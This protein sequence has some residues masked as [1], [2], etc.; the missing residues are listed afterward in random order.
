MTSI[1]KSRRNDELLAATSQ[2]IRDALRRLESDVSLSPSISSLA[3]LAG[4]HRNTIYNHNWPLDRLKSIKE[5]RRQAKEMKTASKTSQKSPAEL[6]ELSRLE[7]VYWFT[8][9][10]DARNAKME[11]ANTMAETESSRNFYMGLAQERL[12]KLNEQALLIDKLR[13]TLDAQE[14]E[15]AVLKRRSE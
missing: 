2:Q 3:K 1:L 12:A 7:V 11:L 15:L 8:Q 9:M 5:R 6:L 14:E 13:N 10:V 4:V